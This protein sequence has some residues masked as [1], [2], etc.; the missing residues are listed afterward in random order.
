MESVLSW[1]VPLVLFYRATILAVH[2]AQRRELYDRTPPEEISGERF[3]TLPNGIIPPPPS[4]TT[5]PRPA[6]S[7]RGLP[8]PLPLHARSRSMGSRHPNRE[9]HL[10]AL[11]GPP[12]TPFFSPDAARHV[13]SLEPPSGETQATTPSAT[14]SAGPPSAFTPFHT[15]A[16]ENRYTVIPGGTKVRRRS[17]T[18]SWDFFDPVGVEALRQMTQL[19]QVQVHTPDV[20]STSITPPH[21][22]TPVSGVL[23]TEKPPGVWKRYSSALSRRSS[24][25]SVHQR[26]PSPSL[27]AASPKAGDEK[28]PS[29]SH[30]ASEASSPSP[31]R[32]TPSRRSARFSY[33]S[34]R[35]SNINFSRPLPI[36]QVPQ[37]LKSRFSAY[38][39][40]AS[41]STDNLIER[42]DQPVLPPEVEA[43]RTLDRGLS[44]AEVEQLHNVP[45]VEGPAVATDNVDQES[46][47]AQ[48]LR[49][50]IRQ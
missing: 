38:S 33:P 37:Q 22:D 46:D 19:D 30:Q 26:L 11:S 21:K 44:A 49:D 7:R 4:A 32:S 10:P 34:R 48:I 18:V 2:M 24:S 35:N 42:T 17:S 27:T 3:E 20:P 29:S 41:E 25:A 28:E 15:F 16:F 5:H 39:E 36:T 8:Q 12:L 43:R 31:P 9:R 13:R 23:R 40:P 50:A 6:P 1:L 14:P 47:F 45:L